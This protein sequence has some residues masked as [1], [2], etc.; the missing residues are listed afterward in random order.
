MERMLRRK[1]PDAAERDAERQ[2]VAIAATLSKSRGMDMGW[3]L[4]GTFTPGS[5]CA[6]P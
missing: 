4:E 1:L 3:G 2:A 5:D 6:R